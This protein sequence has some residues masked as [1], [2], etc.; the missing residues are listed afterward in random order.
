MN[1]IKW[2][3]QDSDFTNEHLQINKIS[4]LIK[5][6]SGNKLFPIHLLSNYYVSGEVFWN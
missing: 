3:G 5:E 1:Y 6:W 4:D 2:S